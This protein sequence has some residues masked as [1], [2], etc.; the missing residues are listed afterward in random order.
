MIIDAIRLLFDIPC[1]IE[2][3]ES[4]IGR[5][6]ARCLPTGSKIAVEFEHMGCSH[7]LQRITDGAEVPNA[8]SK[9]IVFSQTELS[10][11][12]MEAAPSI[13]LLDVH[14]PNIAELQAK[15]RKIAECAKSNF[16]GLNQLVDNASEL[17]SGVENEQ[18]G[19]QATRSE[20]FG[21]VG[22]EDTARSLSDLVNIENWHQQTR[23][24]FEDWERDFESPSLP[25]VAASPESQ[26]QLEI[27]DYIPSAAV[28]EAIAEFRQTTE[29][30][31]SLLA[32]KVS[33]ALAA[34]ESQ[35]QSL[36]ADVKAELGDAQ[37]E[38]LELDENAKKLRARITELDSQDHELSD[39]DRRIRIDLEEF[40]R[41]IDQASAARDE[42][43]EERK[44][45]CRS[46]NASMG[47]FF[48]SFNYGEATE[49]M[50]DLLNDLRTGSRLHDQSVTAVRDEFDRKQFIR[51]AISQKRFPI[52]ND[53][54]ADS[55]SVA[56]Y[57][58]KIAQASMEKQ[59][60][61]GIAQLTVEW[62]GDGISINYKPT[63]G[64]PIPFN[65]LSEGLKALAIKEISFAASTLPAITDQPEDAIPTTAVFDSLV[66]T[67]RNQR[68]RRQFIVASHDA[69]VVVAGD[70]ERVIALPPDAC[71]EPT[72]GT[73]FDQSIKDR[74]IALLEGGDEA[75]E[76]RRKRYGD[77]R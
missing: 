40:D 69:N 22:S 70:V 21:I 55:S 6:L 50:D 71:D 74:A 28:L 62:P 38:I 27:S 11:R 30:A 48:V 75:F 41:L 13:S 42:L 61:D 63:S 47:S 34:H 14:S 77:Y 56:A 2:D 23:D 17:R 16:R 24:R 66:P 5:R 57:M 76:I 68:S 59:K 10:R 58:K 15:V 73:L 35:M 31:A 18:D 29:D 67:I 19:L 60:Y 49:K 37:G 25:E 51:Y 44:A 7:A 12:S 64:G 9:P 52:A 1:D 33:L 45:A 26:S 32:K 39:I 72:S 46:I 20:Y 4:T 65:D 54:A 53:G 43:R 36:R 3:V 8:P